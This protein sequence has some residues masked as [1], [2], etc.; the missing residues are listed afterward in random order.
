M[1]EV[2]LIKLLIQQHQLSHFLVI[3]PP[4]ITTTID[5]DKPREIELTLQLPVNRRT[6]PENVR[7]Y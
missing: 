4:K 3:K 1:K 6:R 5:Y 7:K 2:L